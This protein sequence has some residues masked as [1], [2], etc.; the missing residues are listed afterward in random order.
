MV[1]RIGVWVIESVD[2]SL[3]VL[4]L[5]ALVEVFTGISLFFFAQN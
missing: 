1:L 4:C 3:W 2:T 5:L